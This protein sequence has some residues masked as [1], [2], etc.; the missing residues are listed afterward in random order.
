MVVSQEE[1]G[2]DLDAAGA[3]IET[4]AP[5]GPWGLAIAGTL[6]ILALAI[7]AL[8]RALALRTNLTTRARGSD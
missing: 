4:F 1:V 6:A 7:G 3:A 8:K 5:G 2:R